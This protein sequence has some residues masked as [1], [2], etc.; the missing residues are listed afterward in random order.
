MA[1]VDRLQI[2]LVLA[3][4]PSGRIP[5]PGGRA[6]PFLERVGR[7]PPVELAEEDLCESWDVLR[8]SPDDLWGAAQQRVILLHEDDL[9]ASTRLVLDLPDAFFSEHGIELD[10]GGVVLLKESDLAGA[11]K[12]KKRKLKPDRSARPAGPAYDPNASREKIYRIS[13]YLTIF[14]LLG[15]VVVSHFKYSWTHVTDE[16]YQQRVQAASFLE[17]I[18]LPFYYRTPGAWWYA[19]YGRRLLNP[20]AY[21][22]A[23]ERY[24]GFL[25]WLHFKQSRAEFVGED[26]DREP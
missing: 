21:E 17:R 11:P 25:S 13:K 15:S 9:A 23:R 16:D 24:G 10:A 12:K 20:P 5:P 8:L 14:F 22:A 6:G 1:E 2:G 26:L 3:E 19:W 18:Q 7:E 4:V